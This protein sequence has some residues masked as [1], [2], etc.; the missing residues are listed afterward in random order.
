MAM[1]LTDTTVSFCCTIK[2]PNKADTKAFL[3]LPPDLWLDAVS[4]H[5]PHSVLLLFW[6]E[7]LHQ[8]VAADLTNVLC[9]L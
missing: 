3:E 9:Y 5:Q 8:Q 2:L 7:W 6:V 4:K 1:M